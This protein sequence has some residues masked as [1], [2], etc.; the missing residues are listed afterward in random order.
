MILRVHGDKRIRRRTNSVQLNDYK[1]ARPLLMEDFQKMCGYCGKNS[2]IMKERFHI[3]HFVPKRLAPERKEDYTNLV[4]ACPKC[5]LSKSG[6]WPTGDKNIAHD[7]I[8]GFVDPATEEYD[9]HMERN[10]QGYIR[11][12][13]LLGENIYKSLNFDVRRTDLYWKIQSLYAIQD[14]LENMSEQLDEDELRYYMECN[15]FLKKYIKEAFEK[16]E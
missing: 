11:G 7:G 13:T 3:D 6:K 9:S 5:N 1:E 15:I 2:E 12:I 14:E 8:V 16:G 10:E 4:L